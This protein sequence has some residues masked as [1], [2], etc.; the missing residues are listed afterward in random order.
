LEDG[1]GNEG[2]ET[3]VGCVGGGKKC[4]EEGRRGGEWKIGFNQGILARKGGK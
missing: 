3:G 2:V 4:E 1:G